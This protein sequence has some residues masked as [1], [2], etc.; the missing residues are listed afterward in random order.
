M[1]TIAS[2]FI[3]MSDQAESV[4]NEVMSYAANPGN[5]KSTLAAANENLLMGGIA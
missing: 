5:V 3:A 4:W 1:D 2:K